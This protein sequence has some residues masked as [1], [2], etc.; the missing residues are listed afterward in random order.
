MGVCKNCGKSF[1]GKRKYCS[2]KCRPKA[3]GLPA[4]YQLITKKQI[5]KKI[6][7]FYQNKKRIPLKEEFYH[8]SAA[9]SKFGS[10][11]KAIKAAGF[12]PNPVLFAKKH[13]ARDGH[14]CDSFT[15]KIIDDWLSDHKIKHRRHVPYP[16]NSSLTADFII[17]NRIIEFFGLSG[18]IKTYDK[19]KRKKQKIC[20]KNNI[21]LIE[22][23]PKDI[24]PKN[25][26]QKILKKLL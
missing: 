13:K 15:E 5:I 21:K 18:E 11:N 25:K 8:R 6:K 7:E 10:W 22:I 23:Y 16:Q 19:L 9:R 3:P 4:D 24:Y 14:H 20:Q 12:D 17:K 2:S 1:L 26:L